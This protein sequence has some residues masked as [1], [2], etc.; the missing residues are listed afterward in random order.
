MP[1]KPEIFL[2]SYHL[3]EWLRNKKCIKL[4]ILSNSRFF[5]SGELYST[6]NKFKLAKVND[7]YKELEISKTCE[8]VLSLGK[9]LIFDFGNIL[10]IS[11]CGMKGHWTWTKEQNTCIVM[12]FENNI[13]VFYDDSL[14]QGLF[15]VV[16]KNSKELVH[17]MKS[18]GPD[19][20]VETTT[21]NVFSNAIKNKRIKNK[22]ICEFLMEQQRISGCGNYLRSEAL[23]RS[24]I[25]PTKPLYLLTDKQIYTIFTN[26]RDLVYESCNKGGLIN[27][28]YKNMDGSP[29]FF[30][31]MC[32]NKSID[33]FGNTINVFNDSNNRV[34]FWCPKVQ[35]Y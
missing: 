35:I 28:S 11:S 3:N 17:I 26:L 8:N 29:G 2:M 4:I 5:K 14:N 9:K 23:Y 33:K 34:V 21:Y 7:E 15:S 12:K 10:I 31:T 20:M 27:S 16:E 30:D 6:S 25:H 22:P 1:E 24:E 32:Y 18:V 13:S 19:I